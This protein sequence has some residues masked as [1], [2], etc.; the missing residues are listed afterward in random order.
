MS[1]FF[2]GEIRAFSFGFVPK[3]WAECQGQ[4]LPI[5]QN[6]A[7]FSLLG[8][9]YGGNGVTNFALPDLRNRGSV[10]QSASYRLGG[11]GGSDSHTLTVSEMPA[12]QHMALSGGTA[13]TADPSG[14]TWGAGEGAAYGTAADAVMAVGA[15]GVTGGNQPHQNMPPY[16]PVTYAIALTGIYPSRQ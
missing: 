8:V 14:A 7:L 13:S 5:N 11:A 15:S 16:L 2:I 4:L 9:F 10:H 6:Q 3:Y 12:H 1:E